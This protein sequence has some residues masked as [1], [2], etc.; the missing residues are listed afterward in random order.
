MSG[1]ADSSST[2]LR[3]PPVARAAT[4]YRCPLCRWRLVLVE[5]PDSLCLACWECAL[6]ACVTAAGLQHV[7]LDPQRRHLKWRQLVEDLYELYCVYARD[8]PDGLMR[9][10]S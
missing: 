6:H 7:Y 9:A 2:S 4:T 8:G 3:S 5:Y 10:L 1:I